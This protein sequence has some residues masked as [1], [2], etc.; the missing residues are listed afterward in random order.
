MKLKTGDMAKSFSA[1]DINGKEINISNY[2]G[3]KVLLSFYRYA[4]CP[5]CNLRIHQLISKNDYFENK[6]LT[7]IAV[8]QSPKIN[9][10]EYVGKQ[11]VPFSIIADPSM[12]LYRLYSVELSFI[13][14]ILG[15]FN[16]SKLKAARMNN[17]KVGKMD[18]KLTRV[19]AD[20]MINEEGKI[21]IAYYG[22]DISD[23]LPIEQIEE[24]LD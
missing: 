17:F 22:K 4:S 2:E 6:G 23:H 20:F 11:D 10:K 12:K 1:Y 21:D 5:L 3:R 16:F 15:L 7:L 14:M 18:G 13:K 19:P 24:Y 9:I 8:F